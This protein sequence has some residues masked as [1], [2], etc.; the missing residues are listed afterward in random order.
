MIKQYKYSIDMRASRHFKS[1]MCDT[2]NQ[3]SL[4]QNY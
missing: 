4:V 3:S 2:L 1:E